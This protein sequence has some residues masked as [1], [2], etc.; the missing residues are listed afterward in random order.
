[1]GLIRAVWEMSGVLAASGAVLYHRLWRCGGGAIFVKQHLSHA[2]H[3]HDDDPSC[4][5]SGAALSGGAGLAA[6]R[7]EG[8]LHLKCRLLRLRLYG[9]VFLTWFAVV[10]AVVGARFNSLLGG[11][12]IRPTGNA[13]YFLPV[14]RS[15]PFLSVGIL[16][17]TLAVYLYAELLSSENYPKVRN[18]LEERLKFDSTRLAS[19][20]LDSRTAGAFILVIGEA[21]LFGCSIDSLVDCLFIRPPLFVG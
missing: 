18:W 20:R 6:S 7:G 19:T 1:M 21:N 12:A 3:L 16:G 11:S 5:A 4:L 10:M 14:L 2:R 9:P 17:G 15:P 13:H 8:P